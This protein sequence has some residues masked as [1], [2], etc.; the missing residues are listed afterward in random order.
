MAALPS[1]TQVAGSQY[2][3][4]E[5]YYRI[6]DP[7]NT[8]SIEA[9]DAA[10]FLKKSGLS[11]I[12][13]S[14]IWDLSD[15]TGKGY[16]NKQGFFVA[17]KLVSLAQAGRPT[18]MDSIVYDLPP[19]KM[20][21]LKIKPV[22]N[23]VPPPV[24]PVTIAPG[25]WAMKDPER[26]KYEQLFE[27]LGPVGGKI[28]G[29]K[30]KGVLMESKLPLDTLGKIWDLADMDKDGMLD[31]HEFVVAMHLVYKA[32]EKHS[33]PN[34][35]P[36]ELL[37]PGKRKPSGVGAPPV[38]PAPAPAAVAL[39]HH[40]PP[41]VPPAP[42]PTAV[43]APVPVPLV[44]APAAMPAAPSPVPWVVSAEE[45]SKYSI[46]FHKTDIDKDG[47]VSG[48]EIKDVFLQ[49]G[50]P[51]DVLANIWGLCD[52]H[53][54]GKL[55]LEQFALAM[56][57]ITRKLKG[58]DPPAVLAP[59]MVPPSMRSGKEIPT[60]SAPAAPTYSN[61]E[62]DMISRDIEELSREKRLL[63]NEIAQ[64]E[65]DIAYKSG[66]VKSLQSELD[67]L[68][69]TLRQLENQKGEASKRLNDLKAQTESLERELKDKLE[70]LEEE[71][72]KVDKLRVQADEQEVILKAQ[73]EE[74]TSKKQE[75]ENLKQEETRLAQQQEQ[76]KQKL[77]TL[78]KGLQD[79]QLHISQAKAK[80][81][82]L[83]EQRHQMSDAIALYDT[84]INTSDASGVPDWSL[85]IEPEF[86]DPDIKKLIMVNGSSPT[87]DN[88][89]GMTNGKDPFSKHNGPVDS[90]KE[91]KS[92]FDDDPS[93]RPTK[94][95]NDPF[96]GSSD[97]FGGSAFGAKDGFSSDPFNAFGS[98]NTGKSDPFGNDPFGD[99]AGAKSPADVSELKLLNILD[100]PASSYTHVCL[101][102]MLLDAIPLPSCMHRLL[103]VPEAHPLAPRAQAQLSLQRRASSPRRALLHPD[104]QWQG[105]SRPA[106]PSA[107]PSPSPDPRNAADDGF[108]ADPFGGSSAGGGFADFA[109]F[110]SKFSDTLDSSSELS[111]V[112]TPSRT[113]PSPGSVT[114]TSASES[115]HRYA[116]FEFTEDPFRNYRYEDPFNIADPFDEDANGNGVGSSPGNKSGPVDP[117]GF[118]SSPVTDK[119]SQPLREDPLF[120]DDFGDSFHNNKKQMSKNVDDMS[121]NNMKSPK[122]DIHSRS[123]TEKISKE[124]KHF[125][126]KDNHQQTKT[127][128]KEPSFLSGK[129]FRKNASHNGSDSSGAPAPA[130]ATAAAFEDQQLSWAAAES[131]RMEEERR[132]R[133]EQENADLA[134]ALALSRLDSGK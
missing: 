18:T 128:D 10:G 41:P 113:A 96:A 38:P 49:S 34:V 63:E 14:K 37:P 102:K 75:L 51:Q 70:E 80:I 22:T 84:A 97:P 55:N 91:K 50:V 24:P 93:F 122:S 105:P 4:Y 42:A 54:T 48:A 110:D 52:S 74:L 46:L 106:Q 62:L 65:A 82:L 94:A 78:T 43:P 90:K 57:L 7:N 44:G 76:F 15:P 124:K 25:D 131:M 85:S 1:P 92:L 88:P 61:P 81:T 31:R 115:T 16:L 66:E 58:I 114:S 56:W 33:I 36:P 129:F 53:Q 45:R 86:R 67:T 119:F 125:W 8:G 83:Q 77:E 40:A 20:G 23:N 69:A 99:R 101:V 9:R 133:Q 28:Q 109:N 11:D 72:K 89:E 27:S 134:L 104:Q 68:S 126:T 127:K 123:L 47:Y 130:P 39:A 3:I 59:E 73:E 107:V 29:N 19:P 30:V 112:S 32:L 100:Y 87:S 64:K 12:V 5:A 118:A 6:V 120:G 60:E 108:G 2:G 132:R 21:D 111:R 117:F 95:L 79:S 103:P 98:S 71:T 35:L 17:L 121:N 116:A 26:M 13:L